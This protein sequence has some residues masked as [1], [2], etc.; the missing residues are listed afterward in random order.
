MDNI[1]ITVKDTDGSTRELLKDWPRSAAVRLLAIS[2]EPFEI[3]GGLAEHREHFMA[4]YQKALTENEEINERRRNH[5]D[6]GIVLTS[7]MNK[8]SESL[9]MDTRKRFL[10]NRKSQQ[11]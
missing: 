9:Y 8:V 7:D 3:T 4:L 6:M 11:L 2:R 1:K 10:E 5:A